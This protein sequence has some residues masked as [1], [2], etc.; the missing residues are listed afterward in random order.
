MT[1]P[2][3]DCG[4]PLFFKANNPSAV[5]LDAPD[6]RKGMAVRLAVRSLS[7]M[8]KEALV[9]NSRTGTVW[10]LASDEG[11]YLAGL[12]E[13]PCPLS[14]LTTG[15]VSS[16][17]NEILALA[18][19]RGIAIRSIK[20]IQDN[21]YT[22]TGSAL[23]GTM[24]GGAKDIE[25]EA[26]IDAD[27]DADTLHALVLD[28]VAASPLNGLMR[29]SVE[30]LF[31]LTHNG[32]EIPLGDAM[33]VDGETL[34]D[35]GD[36][37]DAAVPADGDWSTL[38]VKGAMTPMTEE[39][40]GFAESSLQDEQNRLL[41]VRG[42]CTLRPDGIKQI[43]QHLYNPHGSIFTYL[44]EEDEADGGKGRAPDAASYIAAGIGFCFM[45]QFGRF[46]KIAKKDLRDYRIVQDAHFSLG[47][48]TAKTGKAGEADPLETHVYLHTGEDDDFARHILDMSEKTCFLHAFC[49]AELKAKVKITQPARAG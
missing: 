25:L 34:A 7:V 28:A 41:H 21:Y 35:P 39:T 37:F 17:M 13:A 18:E 5:G 9:L 16:Y 32:T 26:V 42:I 43:E 4:K 15:M 2:L 22:M 31:A 10:R 8:Q 12:D 27:A 46:A 3:I 45:T 44:C 29:K 33:P 24:I 49:K 48:A 36:R 30:S 1:N 6:V 47:G 11:A 14:F 38:I 19:I 23:R 20:L 40:E